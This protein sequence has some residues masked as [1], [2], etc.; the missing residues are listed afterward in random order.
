[1]IYE[2]VMRA[3]ADLILWCQA[4]LSFLFVPMEVFTLMGEEFFYIG[5][6]PL[7]YWCVH[8]ATGLRLLVLLA[9][10]SFL[11]ALLKWMFHS[12]RPYWW[13]PAVDGMRH[14][15]GFCPP[16]GHSQNAVTFWGYLASSYA[17]FTAAA[18]RGTTWIWVAFVVLAFLIS[19]SRMILGVHFPHSLVLGWTVGAI[20]LIA[21]I[22]LLPAFE[23]WFRSQGLVVQIAFSFGISFALLA[24]MWLVAPYIASVADIER[25]VANAAAD[26]PG[27]A[28]K[29]AIDPLSVNGF[30]SY[31]AVL[32]GA[33]V[34]G[35][36]MLR[37]ARFEAGGP[38]WQ[39]AL[40]Y[41]LGMI[42]LIAIYVSGTLAP[43]E[44]EA[45]AYAFRYARYFLM[46]L[47]AIWLAPLMFLRLGLV[48]A[49]V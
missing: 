21:Y 46:M 6:I 39:R 24:V 7:I 29:P 42:V 44:P 12:P 2:P 13:D 1:M 4:N 14:E 45:L 25:W 31:A 27:T 22:K 28:K 38:L 34:G 41:V 17:R 10:S 37:T 36:L 43:K 30:Y 48:K 15:T 23:T 16:S 5:L 26:Q 40:R 47:W 20:T 35:A 18:G 49:K 9:F 8:P 32:A 11:N 19:I 3:G 33:G